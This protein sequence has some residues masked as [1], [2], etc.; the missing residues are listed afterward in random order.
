MYAVYT[1]VNIPDGTPDGGAA[2]D[3]GPTRSRPCARQ[4]RRTRTGCKR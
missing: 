4:A 2:A 3:L 1:E